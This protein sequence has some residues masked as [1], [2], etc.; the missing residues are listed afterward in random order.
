MSSPMFPKLAALLSLGLGALLFLSPPAVAQLT[1]CIPLDLDDK[2]NFEQRARGI[3]F[4]SGADPVIVNHRGEYFL[5]VTISGGWWHSKDLVHWRFIHPDVS[6]QAWP[7]EDMCAPAA[8]SVSNR[9]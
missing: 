8:L 5:F 7:K 4:R 6:P 2:Y 9:L 3:S 1:Y